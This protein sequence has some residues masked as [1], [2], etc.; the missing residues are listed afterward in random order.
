MK[1][2]HITDP[3]VRPEG[4]RIRA[5]AISREVYR[6]RVKTRS[7]STREPDGETSSSRIEK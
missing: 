4:E 7:M 2:I 5:I 6:L 1:I 3:H